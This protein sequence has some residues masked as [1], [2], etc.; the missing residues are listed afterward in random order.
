[1]PLEKAQLYSLDGDKYNFDFMFNPNE[2]TI[3]RESE[4]SSNEGART[5]K[6]LPKVSFAYPKAAKIQISNIII[7]TYEKQNAEERNVGNEIK[8]LTQ[9]IKFIEGNFNRP[10]I[11]LFRWGNINYLHCYVESINYKLTLFLDDGTP[12]RAQV[13]LTLKEVDP[14]GVEQ[15]PPAQSNL[16]Q[17]DTRW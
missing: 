6:G 16:R 5:T 10:P 17:V 4:V 3:T 12:V 8:K 1:M 15:N 7:D 11:Y 9:T 2:L 14:T 13:S